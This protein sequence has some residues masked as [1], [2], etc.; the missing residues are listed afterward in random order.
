MIVAQ[1]KSIDGNSSFFLPPVEII[2]NQL[3]ITISEPS[4]VNSKY[5]KVGINEKMKLISLVKSGSSII[6][7]TIV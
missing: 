4:K 5:K 2:W 6:H 3:E 1:V 7:V